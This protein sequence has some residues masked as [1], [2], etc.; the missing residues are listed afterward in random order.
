MNQ[1]GLQVFPWTR[2]IIKTLRGTAAMS[3]LP[4]TKPLGHSLGQLSEGTK[5]KH[6][7]ARKFSGKE[8]HEGKHFLRKGRGNALHVRERSRF[9]RDRILTPNTMNTS[10]NKL[11]TDSELWNVLESKISSLIP[12]L[13]QRNKDTV[14][15]QI[16]HG[17]IRTRKAS[18]Q[19]QGLY[20][21]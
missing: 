20:S 9:K 10:W 4:S 3:M 5:M 13:K 12:F 2:L 21:R 15:L 6:V 17:G 19:C 18:I 11:A 14:A 7:S 16:K 8:L 1:R